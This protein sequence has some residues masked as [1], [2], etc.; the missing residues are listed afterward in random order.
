MANQ[1]GSSS[2]LHE[3]MTRRLYRRSAVA[4]RIVLPAV[5]SM[6]DDHV[7]MC[8]NVFADVGRAFTADE[9]GQ[10]KQILQRQLAEA[11][12]KSPRSS[13]V[14]TYDAPVASLLSYEVNIDWSS[15]EE[16]YENWVKTRKP[17][18]FGTEPDARVWDLAAEAQDPAAH[19][20]LDIGAGTGRNALALARRGHPVDAVELTPTFAAQIA[21]EAERDSLQVRVIQGDVFTSTTELRDDYQLILLSEVVPDFRSLQQV[22][23]I[24]EL[25]A[26][27]L[28]PGGQLVFNVFVAKPFY[29]PDGAA[30]EFGQQCY[31]S[32]FTDAELSMAADELPLEQ[33]SDESVYEYEKAHL[34]ADAWPPTSWYAEWVSGQDVFDLK[35]DD[36][37]IEMR[38]RVYRK[39]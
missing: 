21:Q 10:L 24:F 20:I 36:C 1:H 27:T 8:G 12:T 30:R 29:T 39:T 19:P 38:W 3:A 33:V 14:V 7:T 6:V 35:R 28:A 22:R 26:R 34:P 13:I 18:L 31:T 25:A 17:P 4:G 23:G 9:L 5:P 16:T 2:P 37:P 32:I 15:L 11:F